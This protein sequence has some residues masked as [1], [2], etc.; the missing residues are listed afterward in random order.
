[1][2][3]PA[4]QVAFV[5]PL[6]LQPVNDPGIGNLGLVVFLLLPG[7]FFLFSRLRVTNHQDQATAVGR[8]LI[9]F[10]SLVDLS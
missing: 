10:H 9:G 6:D 3:A 4:V 1:M 5:V 7:F 2:F 8:P